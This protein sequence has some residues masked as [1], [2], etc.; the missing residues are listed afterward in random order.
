MAWQRVRIPLPED[1]SAAQRRRA[2]EIIV[3]GIVDRT[4]QGMGIRKAGDSFRHKPFADYSKS[5]LEY[6]KAKGKYRGNVDLTFEGKMLAALK[7]LS[8]EKG[9]VLIGFDNGTEENDKAEWNRVGT[10]SPNRDFLGM[11]RSEIRAV[12]KSV[13]D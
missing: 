9:S 3:Q 13:K 6:K 7:L 2:G 12:V 11:T 10:N 5:Y 4:K 1:L 8:H